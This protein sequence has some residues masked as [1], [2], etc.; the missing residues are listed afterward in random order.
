LPFVLPSS[1]VCVFF[2][3]VTSCQAISFTSFSLLAISKLRYFLSLQSQGLCCLSFLLSL[4]GRDACERT[5]PLVQP[6]PADALDMIAVLVS[7]KNPCRGLLAR[8]NLLKCNECYGLGANLVVAK[9]VS[10]YDTLA[11]R[12]Y[13]E[14]QRAFEQRHSNYRISLAFLLSYFFVIIVHS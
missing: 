1:F 3:L 2:F 13:N 14:R 9:S 11:E 7:T 12:D 10:Q 6:S 8:A 4:Q 5:V